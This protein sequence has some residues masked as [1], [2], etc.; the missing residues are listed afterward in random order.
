MTE[1]SAVAPA[2]IDLWGM[3]WIAPRLRRNTSLAMTAIGQTRLHLHR[4]FTSLGK[5]RLIDIYTQKILLQYI[6][7]QVPIN[8]FYLEDLHQFDVLFIKLSCDKTL[9]LCYFCFESNWMK[10]LLSPPYHFWLDLEANLHMKEMHVEG[11]LTR[12]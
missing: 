8:F 9:G 10:R 7:V 4:Y 3:I 5:V 6:F 12:S 1:V 11:L 2:P